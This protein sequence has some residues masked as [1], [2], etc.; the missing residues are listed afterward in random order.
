M[1]RFTALVS[2]DPQ[3]FFPDKY[4]CFLKCKTRYLYIL[5]LD[6]GSIPSID[7]DAISE[8]ITFY[9]KKMLWGR[10]ASS[11]S[12]MW[13]TQRIKSG[14][15]VTDPSSDISTMSRIVEHVLTQQIIISILPH[16]V[17]VFTLFERHYLPK[18]RLC[19]CKCAQS[20]TPKYVKKCLDHG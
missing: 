7:D 14:H 19:L 9:M 6:P 1:D 2:T 5:Y 3:D 16:Q 8:I 15:D 4:H 13:P 17:D 11:V 10:D 20:P 12:K 18:S